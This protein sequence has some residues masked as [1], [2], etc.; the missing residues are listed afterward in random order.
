[1]GVRIN[2]ASA[3]PRDER[4]N[5]LLGLKVAL[6][7]TFGRCLERFWKVFGRFFEVRWAFWGNFWEIPGRKKEKLT[8]THCKHTLLYFETET[9]FFSGVVESQRKLRKATNKTT[10]QLQT[11]KNLPTTYKQT[12]KNTFTYDSDT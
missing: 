7:S 9:C 3:R 5:K 11:Y 4:R 1:M 8:E 10:K 2:C 12:T 6:R